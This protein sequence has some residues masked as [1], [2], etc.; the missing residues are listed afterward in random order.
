MKVKEM[1]I[2]VFVPGHG[3]VGNGELLN[4]VA[5]YVTFLTNKSKAAVKKKVSL[6]TFISTFETPSKYIN[7]RGTN[8]I[9]D[10]LSKVYGFF[11]EE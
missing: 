1:E 4:K 3:N 7:W 2:E 10:N 5:G 9:R 8:G 11:A 6:E